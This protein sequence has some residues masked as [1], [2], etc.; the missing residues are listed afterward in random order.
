M[1]VSQ[2]GNNLYWVAGEEITLQVSEKYKSETW[3]NGRLVRY[4][5]N[6]IR[7]HIQKGMS[8][9]VCPG[10]AACTICQGGTKPRLFYMTQVKLA[11]GN[12]KFAELIP[13]V[14]YAIGEAQATAEALGA[15]PEV[16]LSMWFRVKKLGAVAPY[17]SV[18]PVMPTAVPVSPAVNAVGKTMDLD[19]P[20]TIP[21]TEQM[22]GPIPALPVKLTKEELEMVKKFESAIATMKQ[23]NPDINVLASIEDTLKRRPNWTPEKRALALK[24]YDTSGKFTLN[25]DA[26]ES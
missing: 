25:A 11:D 9:T 12:M 26:V 23:T 7:K 8:P 13:M 6:P 14:S 21:S 20:S 22:A 3:S 17:W 15:K 10:Q 24:M 2:N 1:T 18:S 4:I 5:G 16:L 19:A